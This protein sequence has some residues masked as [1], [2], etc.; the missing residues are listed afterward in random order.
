VDVNR[1]ASVA[2][3]GRTLGRHLPGPSVPFGP[4]VSSRSRSG[5]AAAFEEFLAERRV[6][7]LDCV[8]EHYAWHLVRVLVEECE[9][10][11]LIPFADL[12]K[13]PADSLPDQIVLIA[14]EHA[15]E[16]ESFVVVPCADERE[17]ADDRDS[18]L[19][20]RVRSCQPLKAAA[21]TA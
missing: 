15:G 16:A 4:V 3:R 1:I 20:D 11:R 13:H 7:A 8:A 6:E 21:R 10:P 9:Q 17:R 2:V 19:P 14:K 12:A 18:P 5:A